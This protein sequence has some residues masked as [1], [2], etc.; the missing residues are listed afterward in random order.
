VAF[1]SNQARLAAHLSW[2]ATPDRAKRTAPARAA[3]DAKLIASIDPGGV[4]SPRDR[5]KAIKNAKSAWSLSMVAAREA[6]CAA[7]EA[8]EAAGPA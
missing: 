5:A 4:M 6:K 7:R 1:D 2:A 8:K 3:K